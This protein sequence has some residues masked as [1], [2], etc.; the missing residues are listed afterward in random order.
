MTFNYEWWLAQT[1]ASGR[2]RAGDER[3]SP[4]RSRR[5]APARQRNTQLRHKDGQYRWVDDARRLIRDA[6]Q[7]CQ[8]VDRWFRTDITE[9]AKRGGRKLLAQASGHMARDRR[10]QVRIDPWGDILDRGLGVGL[11]GLS[12]ALRTGSS[13]SSATWILK[14]DVDDQVD[15]DHDHRG[16]FF[17]AGTAAV[18]AAS[19]LAR[20]G[21]RA[22][23]P[24]PG[25]EQRS[26]CC[27]TEALDQQVKQ[28]L[29][30]RIEQRIT[31]RCQRGNRGAASAPGSP[32]GT[33][34]CGSAP[35]SRSSPAAISDQPPPRSCER[36]GAID[37]IL[38]L[39]EGARASRSSDTHLSSW[40]LGR[41][42]T[43]V[44]AFRTQLDTTG[45]VG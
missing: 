7:V 28:R 1:F 45:V 20:D 38:R 17:T 43:T 15:R 22:D 2:S 14:Y 27:I 19:S 4:K 11:G 29:P 40:K 36:G 21:I 33:A 41:S 25:A 31:R 6:L 16:A 13:P 44:M 34:S 37:A 9:G 35:R 5:R 8:P 30:S 12:A 3:A 10:K 24:P 23:E 39:F 42:C 32:C 18:F 26:G